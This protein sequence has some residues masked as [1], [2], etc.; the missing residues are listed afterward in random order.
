MKVHFSKLNI[1]QAPWPPRGGPRGH[2]TTPSSRCPAGVRRKPT[3]AANLWGTESGRTRR[4]QEP[5]PSAAFRFRP[6]SRSRNRGRG[7]ESPNISDHGVLPNSGSH[8]VQHRAGHPAGV[9]PGGTHPRLQSSE[10]QPRM[11]TPDPRV[12]CVGLGGLQLTSVGFRV[13]RPDP[14]RRPCLCGL[15]GTCWKEA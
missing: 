2:H 1:S 9:L 7:C 11:E 15:G 10:R 8:G 3:P 6:T 13:R 4:Q 5:H 14:S 12:H